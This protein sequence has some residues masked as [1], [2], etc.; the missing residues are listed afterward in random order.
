V[1]IGWNDKVD[2]EMLLMVTIGSVPGRHYKGFRE[3]A[4]QASG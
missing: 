4:P 3:S 1:G 2:F